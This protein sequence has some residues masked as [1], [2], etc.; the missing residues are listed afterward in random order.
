[1]MV[2]T[3]SDETRDHD[4][5]ETFFQDLQHAIDYLDH[6]PAGFF[7]AE[8]DGSIAHM[9][10]TLAGWLD[11]DL[12]QFSAGRLKIDD[13]VAGDGGAMLAIISGPPGEVT[14]QQ[15]DVDLKPRQGRLL[16]ARILHK[17]A[18]SG[19]GAPGPSRSLVINR[20]PG[21]IKGEDL[22][23][24]EV[25]FAR[26]F[27]S[28][29][30]A[31]AAV[32]AA[33]AVLRPNAA[34]ARLAQAASKSDAAKGRLSIFD[35]V[36][37]RDRAPL[38]ASIDAAAQGKGEIAPLDVSLEGPGPRVR[39]G[40]SSRPPIRAATRA[41]ARPS[42][43][44]TPPSS[45]PC[46]RTSCKAR[47]CRPS[48]SS[49]AA[50]RMTST[51]CLTAIIGYSDLLLANHRP[52]DPSF[53]DI[54]QI[55][56]NANRAAGLVRQLLAF[57]RRQTLRPQTLQ[58]NDVLSELQMLLRRLVGEQIQLD[59]VYG[60]DLWQVKADLN[61]FEQVIVNLV[62]NA[63]DAMQR[64]RQDHAAHAQLSRRRMRRLEGG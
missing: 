36:A 35:L 50:S 17:V 14:T 28:T 13:I 26:I 8:P 4:R 27:N 15:F 55:K 11:Y 51:T 56:Q 34:F 52:T 33:G 44:S 43:R 18:F 39:R 38:S 3:V 53:Q 25:R 61:Q 58:L 45:A 10:A 30:V 21:D 1:M 59:V 62:V 12:A 48:A 29:P 60:R 31:I 37:E 54:M 6:A 42:S 20:A 64:R 57:S 5:H 41:R 24:A 7:S 47:R 22:R 40:S 49:P 63:R 46:K 23:A 2:W 32:D 16:P 9:N 19:D